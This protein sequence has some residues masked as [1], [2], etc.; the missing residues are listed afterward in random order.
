M[1]IFEIF[2]KTMLFQEFAKVVEME[3]LKGEI[4]PLFNSLANDEQVKLKFADI[5]GCFV[6]KLKSS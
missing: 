1:V 6:S 5:C 4:I 3:H 2:C